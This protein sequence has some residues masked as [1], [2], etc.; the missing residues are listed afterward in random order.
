MIICDSRIKLSGE[1]LELLC[2]NYYGKE[3][4]IET[5]FETRMIGFFSFQAF[6]PCLHS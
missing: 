1:M 5:F 2:L 4:L 3:P 6:D